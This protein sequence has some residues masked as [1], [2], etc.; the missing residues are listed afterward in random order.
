[1]GKNFSLE[2]YFISSI[3]RFFQVL[4]GFLWSPR[5]DIDQQLNQLLEQVEAFDP[6]ELE[7]EVYEEITLVVCKSC[8]DR[9]VDEPSAPLGGTL[10]DPERPR[11]SSIESIES[12]SDLVF[13]GIASSVPELF[14]V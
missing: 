6:K 1:M 10:S 13:I 12:S 7:K 9:F 2:A 11:L 4:T 3:S 8:R 14:Q 5:G